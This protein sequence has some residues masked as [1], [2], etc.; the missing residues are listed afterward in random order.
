MRNVAGMRIKGTSRIGESTPRPSPVPSEASAGAV[1]AAAA[2]AAAGKDARR[3]RNLFLGVEVIVGW[4]LD[5]ETLVE[6]RYKVGVRLATK[7]SH[8][9]LVQKC[10]SVYEHFCIPDVCEERFSAAGTHRERTQS[11]C[12][13]R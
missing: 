13:N 1:A 4:H 6:A 8:I 12:L 5:D 3:A 2:I 11:S 7:L 9:N 10:I